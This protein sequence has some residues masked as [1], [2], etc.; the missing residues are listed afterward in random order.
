LFSDFFEKVNGDRRCAAHDPGQIGFGN[1]A[2]AGHGLYQA[3]QPIARFTRHRG[4]AIH[5]IIAAA[6]LNEHVQLLFIDLKTEHALAQLSDTL[7][8]D[9]K[10]CRR[11][12][13]LF[14]RWELQQSGNLAS[15]MASADCILLAA[16]RESQEWQRGHGRS[17]LDVE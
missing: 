8:C 14:R 5:G 10:R 3:S 9:H 2:M 15:A 11:D 4:H 6:I 17:F 1:L 13:S 12:A 16:N 7:A